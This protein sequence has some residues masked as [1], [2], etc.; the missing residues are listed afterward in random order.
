M[1]QE[2]KRIWKEAAFGFGIFLAVVVIIITTICLGGA[3]A[4]E[5]VE[6]VGGPT[7]TTTQNN[8]HLPPYV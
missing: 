8:P 2:D 4:G 6:S 1:S 5:F 7:A 3:A